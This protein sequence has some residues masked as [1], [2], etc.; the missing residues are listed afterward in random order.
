M[1]DI[2]IVVDGQPDGPYDAEALRA[3]LAS[4]DFPRDIRASREGD[5]QWMP[6]TELIGEAPVATSKSGPPISEAKLRTG[7][8]IA[9]GALFLVAFLFPTPLNEGWGIV[10][11]QT[12]WVNEHLGWTPIPLMLWPALAGVVAIALGLLLYGRARAAVG[13]LLS[14]LPLLLLVILGGGVGMQALE[15]F[16]DLSETQWVDLQDKDKVKEKMASLLASFASMS[17]TAMLVVTAL[18]GVMASLYATALLMPAAVRALRPE[19]TGAYYAGLIGGCLLLILQLVLLFVSVPL[20]L[21]NWV[22][23]AGQLVAVLMHMAAIIIGFTNTMSRPPAVAVRRGVWALGLG[24]GGCM[25]YGVALL[26]SALLAEG[27]QEAFGLYVFKFWL[28]FTA[29]VMVLP[30]AL[31][32]LWLGKIVDAPVHLPETTRP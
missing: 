14:L 19:S 1:G 13:L 20:L 12:G 17:A 11:L 27:M 3:R 26:G 10:N 22:H 9:L 23:G 16:T 5:D 8:W 24:V 25:V 31:A 6:L 2:F 7:A 29:A 30:L 4:G 18:A 21:V 32:D 28:W 15:M